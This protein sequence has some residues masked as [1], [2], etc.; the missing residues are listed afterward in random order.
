MCVNFYV[1]R[2]YHG[3]ATQCW[4]R[5]WSNQNH[6]SDWKGPCDSWVAW[7]LG[8]DFAGLQSTGN[9]CL[10]FQ[11]TFYWLSF[12]FNMCVCTYRESYRIK[13]W[14]GSKWKIMSCSTSCGVPQGSVP[15]PIL[16]ILY[17][18]SLLFYIQSMFLISCILMTHTTVLLQPC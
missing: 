4:S 16:L 3:I 17:T 11:L 2:L 18:K 14:F 12:Y 8:Q 7:F 13:V 10:V 9:K 1:C 15:G 6:Q 5:H